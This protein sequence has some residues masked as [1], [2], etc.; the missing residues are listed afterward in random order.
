[1]VNEWRIKQFS[2][3][4]DIDGFEWH[5][6]G[7]VWSGGESWWLR[8]NRSPR[9]EISSSHCSDEDLWAFFGPLLR[10]DGGLSIVCRKCN[11]TCWIKKP[12]SKTEYCECDDCEGYGRYSTI[13]DAAIAHVLM[14]K[15]ME[16]ILTSCQVSLDN[17]PGGVE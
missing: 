3:F 1:M 4:R 13:L 9:I 17:S 5:G 8:D 15:M 7:P 11:G 14:V 16:S 12:F 2:M 10:D 6:S